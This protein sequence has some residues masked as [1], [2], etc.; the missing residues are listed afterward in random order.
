MFTTLKLPFLI[1]LFFY[2]CY[3]FFSIELQPMPWYDETFFASMAH[4]YWLHGT[5][6]PE[7]AATVMHQN[8][9]FIYGP[10]Y[11][12]LTGLSFDCF[13][14]GV[15]QFRIVT[16]IFG[17]AVILIMMLLK[18]RLVKQSWGTWDMVWVIILLT[19]P[20]FNLS[21]H[22]GRMD[23]VALFFML[24]AIYSFLIAVEKSQNALFVLVG[25]CVALAVLTTPRLGFIVMACGAAVIYLWVQ[26]K[27]NFLQVVLLVL[28]ILVLYGSWIHFCGGLNSFI[29]VYFAHFDKSGTQDTVFNYIGA[30]FYIPRHE[31]LLIA[32]SI[33]I[34]VVGILK[35]NHFLKHY[36]AWVALGSIC[37]FYLLIKD[38][39]PYSIFILPFY[40]LLCMGLQKQ[41]PPVFFKVCIAVL[42]AFNVGFF[43]LKLI[44]TMVS[45]S[46]RNPQ[47]AYDFVRQHI[48]KGS[49]VIGDATYYYAVVKH[50]AS[51]EYIDKY[52]T[53]NR[54]EELLRTKYKYQYVIVSDIEKARYVPTFNYFASK[55]K[56]QL[57]AQL[58][59]SPSVKIP[60]VSSF[61]AQGYACRLYKVID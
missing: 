12:V 21:L 43:G 50:G 42:L 39:G 17:L 55:S 38:W 53:L 58:R 25:I 32:F 26:Q 33:C 57:V 8:Q 13:G 41:S 5:L 31:Y 59:V 54:R 24:M 1:C 40:Y 23:L 56:L 37:L 14:F 29:D 34:V 47:I 9:V 28:P 4:N 18:K 30:D 6:V 60:L 16:M 51:Y 44:Q 61:D 46:E 52:A 15:W 19:D 11:C 49:K 27:L 48:P 2:L 45:A 20:F 7:I 22:E 10:V 36:F 3:L 35:K